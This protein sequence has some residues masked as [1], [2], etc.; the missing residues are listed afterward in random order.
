VRGLNWLRHRQPAQDLVEFGLIVAV[1]GVV[2]VLGLQAVTTAQR[3]YFGDL[4]S[5]LAP[6][7]LSVPGDPLHTTTVALACPPIAVVGTP[8]PC[9]VIVTDTNTS[10][11]TAPVGTVVPTD[12]GAG[13]SFGACAWTQS[14]A[15]STCAMTYIPAQSGT[16]TLSAQFNPTSRHHG[17]QSTATLTVT[18]LPELQIESCGNGLPKPPSGDVVVGEP[19][20]CQARLKVSG[21]S[22]GGIAGK[23]LTWSRSSPSAGQVY[24]N[25]PSAGSCSLPI[26]DFSAAQCTTD[27]D[28][29]C[30]VIVRGG[31]NFALDS[32]GFDTFAVSFGGDATYQAITTTK[33]IQ[34]VAAPTPNQAQATIT[35]AVDKAAGTATCVIKITDVQPS[36]SPNPDDDVRFP[37]AGPVLVTAEHG[38]SVTCPSLQRDPGSMTTSSC[39][40][41]YTKGTEDH[42]KLTADYQGERKPGP[43]SVLHSDATETT[44]VDFH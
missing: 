11:P 5:S 9:S 34:V 30:T 12:S 41:V 2:G 32:L 44:D 29:R 7:P 16:I 43:T 37:P 18:I 13:G 22:G 20:T 15:V 39:T 14:G 24:F 17:G 35:C 31:F 36:P 27:S 40:I 6:A 8:I 19:L 28:G 25:C 26:S 38:G 21:G 3:A 10:A 23:T 33:S 1:V 4:A 42:D